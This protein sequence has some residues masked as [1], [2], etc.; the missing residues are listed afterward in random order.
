M[1]NLK[2]GLDL[3]SLFIKVNSNHTDICWNGD[4]SGCKEST[5]FMDSIRDNFLTQ[6]VKMQGGYAF[7]AQW[8]LSNK[9][10]LIE[11]VVVKGNLGRT[12]QETVEFK[13]LEDIRKSNSQIKFVGIVAWE[14]ALKD[15]GIQESWLTFSLLKVQEL[16]IPM[17]KKPSIASLA[18]W[19][20]L[21]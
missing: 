13:I 14:T 20:I 9:K 10:E 19:V 7:L 4:V 21:D 11:N 17:C 8:L 5:R 12:E 6:A 18:E 16:S 1:K 15:K 3:N 2:E